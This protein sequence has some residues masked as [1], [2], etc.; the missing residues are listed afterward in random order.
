[1]RVGAIRRDGAC[2]PE[3]KKS[4]TSCGAVVAN[5]WKQVIGGDLRRAIF[6]QEGLHVKALQGEG[7]VTT[8]FE[9]VHHLVP[10]PF[11][12]NAQNLHQIEQTD[13]NS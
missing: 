9:G 2:Q 5:D 7:H 6:G 13:K 10:E 3:V 4:R 8:D 12:M 1:M 11:Q